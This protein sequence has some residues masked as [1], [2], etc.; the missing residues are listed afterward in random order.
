MDEKTKNEIIGFPLEAAAILQG[1][2]GISEVKALS[3]IYQGRLGVSFHFDNPK[4]LNNAYYALS[5]KDRKW[6]YPDLVKIKKH[7]VKLRNLTPFINHYLNQQ[8]DSKLN[9]QMIKYV[10]YRTVIELPKSIK[11]NSVKYGD[12]NTDGVILTYVI[13]LREMVTN[14]QSTG[15]KV[16][17]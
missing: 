17:Y 1:I 16:R 4:A 12:V 5:Q 8:Q 15:N 14:K 13:P 7:K 9:D 3:K 10:N 11:P 2:N 6:Y